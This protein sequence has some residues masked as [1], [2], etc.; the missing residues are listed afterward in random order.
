ME[1]KALTVCCPWSVV[2]C[3]SSR[4]RRLLSGRMGVA[5]TMHL[6][7]SDGVFQPAGPDLRLATDD[8]PRTT[9]KG[10]RTTDNG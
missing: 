9:D 4:A 6:D 8:G 5:I 3:P 10:R 1:R 2:S 7:F